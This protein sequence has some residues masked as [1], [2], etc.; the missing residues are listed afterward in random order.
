[1]IVTN[2]DSNFLFYAHDNAIVSKQSYPSRGK[3]Y[4]VKFLLLGRDVAVAG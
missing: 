3:V 1:M 2:R 4:G